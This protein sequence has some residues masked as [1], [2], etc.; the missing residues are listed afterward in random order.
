LGQAPILFPIAG[1]LKDDKYILNGKEY[2][3]QKHGYARFC[4]FEVGH[5]SENSAQFILRSDSKS[6]AIF[7]FEYELQIIYTLVKNKL[8][9]KYVVE[10][11]SKDTMYF[12]IGA[13]E[14][15]SCPEGIEE[16]SIIF[17]KKETLDHWVLNGNLLEYK[18]ERI[19]EN[20]D[21]LQLDY[22]YFAIDALVFKN[23]KSRSVILKHNKSNK[24]VKVDFDGFDY[25]L[26][27]TKPGAPYICIEPWCGIP[28]HVDSNYDITKKEGIQK[29][30]AGAAFERIHSITIGD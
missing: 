26:F 15:Y 13:H 27:W 29:L 19:I 10:N 25:L 21:V 12:S 20:S 18:T 24:K 16:Y 6:M 23:V 7:P 1:G 11:K 9:V 5:Q 14:G 28:D 22:K 4:E 17:E 2:T 3:L 8:E 30:A